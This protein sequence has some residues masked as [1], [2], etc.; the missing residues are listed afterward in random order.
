M[1]DYVIYG[2]QGVLAPAGTPPAVIEQLSQAVSK[3]LA[4]PDLKSRLT[5]QGTDPAYLPPAE[6]RTYITG[7]QKRWSD[8]IRSAKIKLD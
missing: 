6:F 7:E 4:T 3:A 2:W 8:V 5:A 1:P